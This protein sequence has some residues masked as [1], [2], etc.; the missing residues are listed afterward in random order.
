MALASHVTFRGIDVYDAY[1][2]VDSICIVGKSSMKVS[3]GTYASPAL[4]PLS[5][6]DYACAYDIDGDNPIRQ[7]Y[8][9]LKSLP[10]FA[11]ATDC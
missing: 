10:E 6:R 3:V 5:A 7:A 11:G 1:H 9:H 2:R 8:L 4:E